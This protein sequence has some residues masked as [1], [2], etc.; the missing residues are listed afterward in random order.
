MEVQ[1]FR[2]DG[3]TV[4]TEK[5]QIRMKLKRLTGLPEKNPFG[6]HSVRCGSCGHPLDL[7]KGNTCTFCG[8]KWDLSR[9]DWCIHEYCPVIVSERS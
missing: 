6:I 8:Q 3:E 5:E 2:L 7:R 4:R 9:Y 1:L